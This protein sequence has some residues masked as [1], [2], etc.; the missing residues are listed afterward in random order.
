MVLAINLLTSLGGD[1]V[2]IGD[3][4]L[5]QVYHTDQLTGTNDHFGS[6]LFDSDGHLAKHGGNKTWLFTGAKIGQW[7]SFVREFDLD[8]LRS[9]ERKLILPVYKND[10]W[11]TAH[12]AIKA[13]EDLY[14][15]FFSTGKQI[16]AAVA[17][18]PEGPFTVDSS[19]G[20]RPNAEWEKGCAIESDCGFVKISETDDELRI[21]K[22]YDTLCEGSTGQNGWAEVRIDTRKRSI[23][24]V[25]K[26]PDNPIKLLKSGIIAARTGG[27][28]DSR[29]RFAGKYGLFYLSKKNNRTYRMAA[30]L[31]PD[32]LLQTIEWNEE[33]AGP[34]G[35]EAVIEKFQWYFHAGHFFVIYENADSRNDW[36][37]SIRKY[38]V[39]EGNLK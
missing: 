32:P 7:I 9:S 5:E 31:G 23:E 18:V 8:T 39:I 6:L 26:H 24:L 16:R 36:R 10:R 21:W 14:V 19:F 11:A 30:A 34:L 38:R 33:I 3:V 13:A 12:L 37:S 2:T 28:V 29:I 17:A 22:L 27:N 20:I 15:I 1:V 4:K 25:Q 35:T